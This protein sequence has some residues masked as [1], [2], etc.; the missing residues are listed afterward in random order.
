[1]K[2]TIKLSDLDSL[3]KKFLIT[4][5]VVLSLGVSMGLVFVN[6]TTSFTSEGAIER[7]R[8]SEEID[9]FGIPKSSS[10]TFY[11]L[12][13]T[14]HNHIIGF[15][16]IFLTIGII[17]YFTETLPEK[18]KIFLMIEPLISI[19]LSFGSIW[20]IKYVDANFVYLTITSAVLMYLSY[21]LMVG[22]IIK[23]LIFSNSSE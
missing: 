17:F 22:I 2:K 20:G 11:E 6:H 19:L 5:V 18:F 13:M 7:F 9:E 3:I 21:Y 1:M 8:G 14:T 23:E 15:S 4:Y 12:L 16:F 10:K